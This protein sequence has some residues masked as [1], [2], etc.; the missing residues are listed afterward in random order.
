[1]NLSVSC[2]GIQTD[3]FNVRVAVPPQ[4]FQT[5]DAKDDK[6]QNDVCATAKESP[7]MPVSSSPGKLHRNCGHSYYESICLQQRTQNSHCSQKF[8][9]HEEYPMLVA[10]LEH[11]HYRDAKCIH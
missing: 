1:M 6:T 2:T 3:V 8:H 5:D 9:S 7:T 11:K 10:Y 4:S